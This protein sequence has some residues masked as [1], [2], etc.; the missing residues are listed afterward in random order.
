M[1][2]TDQSA[3]SF[4]GA[5]AHD[6]VDTVNPLKIGGRPARTKGLPSQAAIWQTSGRS[7]WPRA[8][9]NLSMRKQVTMS[10]STPVPSGSDITMTAAAAV[11]AGDLTIRDTSAH[12]FYIPVGIRGYRSCIIYGT[13]R[14]IQGDTAPTVTIYGAMDYSGS[15]P[16]AELAVP[17]VLRTA[18]SSRMAIGFSDV[19]W[20]GL[21]AWLRP[22][23]SRRAITMSPCQRWRMAGHISIPDSQRQ[24]CTHDRRDFDLRHVSDESLCGGGGAAA[25]RC[26]RQRQICSLSSQAKATRPARQSHGVAEEKSDWRVRMFHNDYT[27][28]TAYEPIDDAVGQVDAVS[29]D[30]ANSPGH[31]FALRAAK[32]L[33]DPIT[34]RN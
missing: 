34:I 4:T 7:V 16:A 30:T 29:D 14:H 20:A 5:I 31:S 33:R 21:V 6:A 8:M 1:L 23:R 32:G 24:Q 25:R 10:P 28:K 17:F 26:L 12:N 15:N 9:F 3:P 2:P 11:V 13:Q 22:R 27:W 18:A 19:A